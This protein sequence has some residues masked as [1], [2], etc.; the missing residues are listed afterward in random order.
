MLR[1]SIQNGEAKGHVCMT[2]GHEQ[3]RRDGWRQCGG[4]GWRGAKG[5]RNFENGP[6]IWRM[7]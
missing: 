6:L 2:H 7:L 5:E 3:R 1:A 4:A